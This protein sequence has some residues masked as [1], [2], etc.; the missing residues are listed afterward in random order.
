MIVT[1]FLLKYPVLISV[2][3]IFYEILCFSEILCYSRSSTPVC[4]SP[5]NFVSEVLN[6]I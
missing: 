2:Y 6:D 4:L 1:S 3:P 5:S